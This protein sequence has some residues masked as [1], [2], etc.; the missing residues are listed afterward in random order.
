LRSDGHLT[1]A[2]AAAGGLADDNGALP[3][4]RVSDAAGQVTTISLQQL[5]RQGQTQLD[6]PLTEG[7]VV[8]VPG[9]MHF[10]VDVSGAVDH[11]GDVQ[12]SEGDRISV[13]IA[14]AGNSANAQSDLNNIK[15]IRVSATGAQTTQTINLYQAINEGDQTADVTLRKGDIVYVPQAKS[16]SQWAQSPLLYLLTRLIP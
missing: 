3:D 9:T 4:A 5:L 7:S 14:K 10:L 12:V 6:R 13:A 15:L 8:Y 2:I 1:D 16:K 11:P